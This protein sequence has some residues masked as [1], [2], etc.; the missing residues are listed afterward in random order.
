MVHAAALARCRCGSAGR[1]TVACSSV[2]AAAVRSKWPRN[3]DSLFWCQVYLPA[4]PSL[5]LLSDALFEQRQCQH[6]GSATLVLPHG[7][8][9]A[10]RGK[11]PRRAGSAPFGV[12]L[13]ALWCFLLTRTF[14]H[15]RWKQCSVLSYSVRLLR[16]T[17][18]AVVV[19]G[20]PSRGAAPCVLHCVWSD[21]HV[22]ASNHSWCAEQFKS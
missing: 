22:V 21:M 14:E 19:W 17:P 7:E 4:S 18:S 12:A 1:G 2:E 11:A 20:R 9:D 3:A 16:G 5:V 13:R 6:E 10:A 15:R 8:S